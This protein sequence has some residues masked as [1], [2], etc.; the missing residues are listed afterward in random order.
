[1]PCEYP[2]VL[3]DHEHHAMTVRCK[4]SDSAVCP[5]CAELHRGDVRTSILEALDGAETA[6]FF[7]LTAPGADAFGQVHS[8]R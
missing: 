4:G 1:M 3:L 2:I 7:T 5:E 6:T 8:Q